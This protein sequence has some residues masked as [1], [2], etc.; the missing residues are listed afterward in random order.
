MTTP[1][2]EA[3]Q[4][5]GPDPVRWIVAQ[6]DALV[7][8]LDRAELDSAMLTLCSRRPVWSR[9]W[10]A[11]VVADVLATLPASDPWRHL[12]ARMVGDGQQM[13]HGDIPRPPDRTGAVSP[14]TGRRFGT[15]QDATDVLG[16]M[17]GGDLRADIAYAALAQPLR[18][19]AAAVLGFAGAGRRQAADALAVVYDRVL[20]DGSRDADDAAAQFVDDREML[21]A[22]ARV[23]DDLVPQGRQMRAGGELFVAGA[24]AVRWAMHR[25]RSYVGGDDPFAVSRGMAHSVVA[26]MVEVGRTVDW[27]PLD[28]AVGAAAI[29]DGEY[30]DLD[31]DGDEDF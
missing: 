11:G 23:V 25:R 9:W 13:T 20:A 27:G 3:G 30:M 22:T 21:F 4:H 29:D 18:A 15:V 31:P 6:H 8:A 5:P 1:G 14:R 24:Q 19:N 28:E 2:Q 16:P 10:F 12:S 26:A 7:P 17:A